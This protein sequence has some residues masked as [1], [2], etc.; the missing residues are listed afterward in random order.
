V[1]P[2]PVLSLGLAIRIVG[3]LLGTSALIVAVANVAGLVPQSVEPGPP[4]LSRLLSSLPSLAAGLVL[5]MPMRYF[6]SGIGYRLLAA[7][8]VLVCLA[9]A[10][11]AISGIIG[12][13]QGSKHWAVVP[14]GL[15]L[16][17]IVCGNGLL[18]LRARQP[19]NV[20]T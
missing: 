14:V 5:L 20:A 8:Y 19:A 2:E 18:L 13:L 4:V 12:Y 16:M 1:A 11:L 6:A 7:A 9:T 3:V 17:A 10:A 15:V